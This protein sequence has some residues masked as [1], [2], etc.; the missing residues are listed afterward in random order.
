[1]LVWRGARRALLNQKKNLN[2]NLIF[3]VG[4]F[5]TIQTQAQSLFTNAYHNDKEPRDIQG[6]TKVEEK[7]KTQVFEMFESEGLRSVF[8]DEIL[9]AVSISSS[10]EDLLKSGVLIDSIL[11][12]DLRRLDEFN[13]K[14][15]R[16]FFRRCFEMNMPDPARKLWSSPSLANTRIITN[17]MSQLY[18]D[19]L[20]N[21]AMYEEVLD[22]FQER[23]DLFKHSQNCLLIV[24]F[25]CY[26]IGTREALDTCLN[27]IVPLISL[28]YRGKSKIEMAAALLAYNLGEF[29]VAHNIVRRQAGARRPRRYPV[30]YNNLEILILAAAGRPAEALRLTR[31]HI[32]PKTHLSSDRKSTIV[33]Q[34]AEG[35]VKSVMKTEDQGMLQELKSL[36]EFFENT[37]QVEVMSKSLEEYLLA[38]IDL[39]HRN[40]KDDF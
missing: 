36:L 2:K 14:I 12:N 9:T 11:S 10:N 20:Y 29:A 34:T 37:D 28:E 30:F 33:N 7:I 18:Y 4:K 25:C 15:T 8:N 5:S 24:S 19:L 38:P 22:E 6:K 40:N 16:E 1:M 35:L 13:S 17:S 32:V 23:Y 39:S 21:C 3:E 31:T 27:T 26:K